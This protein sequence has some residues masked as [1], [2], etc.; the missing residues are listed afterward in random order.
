MK[1]SPHAHRTQEDRKGPLH[2]PAAGFAAPSA[3]RSRRS[4]ALPERWV[5]DGLSLPM[6]ET[7]NPERCVYLIWS[8]QLDQRY[9]VIVVDSSFSSQH[10]LQR[11]G[12]WCPQVLWDLARYLC[13]CSHRKNMSTCNIA[14]AEA[15]RLRNNGS[16]LPNCGAVWG[17]ESLYAVYS[18]STTRR[19]LAPCK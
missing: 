17:R 2:G 7:I 16:N 12:W 6:Q 8:Q 11:L 9:T 3:V 1:C 19:T 15:D 10:F 14:P 4:L 13:G 18:P 5:L